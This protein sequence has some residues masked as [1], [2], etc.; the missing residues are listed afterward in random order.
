MM[1][2][3]SGVANKEAAKVDGKHREPWLNVLGVC[4][5]LTPFAIDYVISHP[6][7]GPRIKGKV[8]DLGA[9]TCWVTAKLSQLERVKEVIAQDMSQKF[10]TT[11]GYRIITLLEGNVSKTKF[12]VSSFN[13]VPFDSESLDCVFLVA[14]IHHSLSPIK[15]FL[16]ANRILKQDGIL[17][18]VEHPCA[19]VNIW[20]RRER[21]L[22]LSRDTGTTELCYTKG[23]LEYM[24]RHA[25]FDKLS[26]YP[27]DI[28]TRGFLRKVVRRAMRLFSLEDVLR[29]PLYV[30]TSEKL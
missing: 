17:I 19:L 23:E 24:L 3:E 29:P 16:E 4:E 26:F 13:H 6:V 10:L 9:G 15:T 27:V 8:I 5:R 21:A 20:K 25:R 7:I 2:Y 11:V 18:V 22:K 30:I 1:R 28:V 14:A 12:A